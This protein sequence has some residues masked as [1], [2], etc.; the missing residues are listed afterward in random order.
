[1]PDWVYPLCRIFKYTTSVLHAESFRIIS[2]FCA[3]VMSMHSRVAFD[4]WLDKVATNA[5]RDIF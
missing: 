4:I 3:Y 2:D 1:M 5:D